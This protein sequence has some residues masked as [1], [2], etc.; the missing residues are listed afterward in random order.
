MLLLF[1][2]VLLLILSLAASCDGQGG[3]VPRMVIALLPLARMLGLIFS[4][5]L[6]A[7]AGFSF[8]TVGHQHA[9]DVEEDDGRH[10]SILSGS[11]GGCRVTAA[12]M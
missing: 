2:S 12:R 10:G 5:G 1:L 3:K 8:L 4:V 7:T 11:P 6:I 9:V